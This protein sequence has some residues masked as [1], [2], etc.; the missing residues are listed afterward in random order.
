[1]KAG[2]IGA[3]AARW[4]GVAGLVVLVASSLCVLAARAWWVFELACELRWQLGLGGIAAALFLFA[5][6]LR[7]TALVA[8]FLACVHLAPALALE[9]GGETAI[10]GRAQVTVAGVNLWH[11]NR[12]ADLVRRW[13]ER[14]RPDVVACFEV[15]AY[16]TRELDA[17]AD[18]YPHRRIV[19]A[20]DFDPASAALKGTVDDKVLERTAKFP[21]RWGAAVLSRVPLE[22]VIAHTVPGSP[23]PYLEWSATIG[24]T[25]FHF[26][27]LHPERPGMPPRTERRD[28]LLANVARST[29]WT[30]TSIVIGDLNSTLYAPIFREFV[31]VAELKDARQGFGRE[32]TWT[33]DLWLPLCRLDLDHVLVRSGIAVVDCR[34]G[35]E[36]GSDH[37]P[38]IAHVQAR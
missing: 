31:A 14:D 10:E 17:L 6:G 20:I 32:A 34:V 21:S 37:R 27:A 19:P 2:S 12:R 13:L 15:S 30:G 22:D 33:P 7:R 26:V 5:G 3:R 25:R 8:A 29:H 23:D 36:I 35:P 18:L 4:I 38:V 28:A 9:F 1:M 16:W 11:S 24:G